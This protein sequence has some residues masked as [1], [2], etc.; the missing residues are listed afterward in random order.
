MNKIAVIDVRPQ[1]L[2]L[3]ELAHAVMWMTDHIVR[4]KKD[5][6]GPNVGDYDH[7]LYVR[8]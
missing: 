4:L 6:L 2:E 7:A 1:K 5:W 3:A 8:Q